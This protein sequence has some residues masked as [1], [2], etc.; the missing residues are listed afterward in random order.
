[1]QF[2]AF[3]IVPLHAAVADGLIPR[4]LEP[5]I[6]AILKAHGKKRK[7]DCAEVPLVRRD[8][9]S[10]TSG[11]TDEIAASYFSFRT[12]LAF[13]ALS[14]R[15]YFGLRYCNSDS[16]RLVVQAFAQE[17]GAGAL[18]T[19]RRRDGH[20]NNYISSSAFSETRPL[21]VSSSF[22][23][24]SDLDIPL[25]H[26]LEARA[27]AGNSS[28]DSLW[29]RLE[30]AIRLFVGANTDNTDLDLHTELVDTVSAFSRLFGVWDEKGT[31]AGFAGTLPA[32]PP[33]EDDEPL[34]PKANNEFVRRALDSGKSMRES[35]LADAYRLR[36]KYGHG[37]VNAPGYPS[38]WQVH[39]HLLLAAFVF[40]LLVKAMLAREGF[41]EFT[42]DDRLANAMF[43]TLA[44]YD[45]FAPD[46][47][48]R[49]EEDDDRDDIDPPLPWR[50]VMSDFH[51]RRLA[52]F[53]TAEL[54]R[55]SIE[56]ADEGLDGE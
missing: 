33:E 20:T 1:M 45:A 12:R 52:K 11:M 6:T 39:E 15:Q 47:N 43:D 40:P 25:M 49:G 23:L 44:S 37:D 55:M 27:A 24:P 19:T 56:T 36:G 9:L 34:G 46:P 53:L 5:A 17:G 42:N 50:R 26:T 38:T 3:H 35:W 54:E 18:I 22:T 8:D 16:A 7:V 21:H 2:G 51:M 29:P 30:D 4:E 41:Y 10:F 31:V 48:P 32:P 28:N 13:A 14:A